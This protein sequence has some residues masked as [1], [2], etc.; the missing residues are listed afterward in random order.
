MVVVEHMPGDFTKSF[1]K[2]LDTL[3]QMAVREAENGDPV[4]C[5]QVLIAPGD[6]CHCEVVKTPEGGYRVALSE[7]EPVNYQRPSVDVLFASLAKS[8]KQSGVGVIMTG[9]GSDGAE[10]LLKMR[11]AGAHTIGQNEGSSVVY[12]MPRAAS[13]LGAVCEEVDLMQIP[14]RVLAATVD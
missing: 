9:M 2:R 6:N 10:G 12:G 11:H 13:K 4:R 14:A 1:A 7:G 5:G 3:S 8:A